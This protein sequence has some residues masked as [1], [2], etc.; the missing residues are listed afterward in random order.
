MSVI[1]FTDTS[2]PAE[3]SLTKK[4][5]EYT[6]GH[7]VTNSNFLKVLLE[8]YKVTIGTPSEVHLV[9]TGTPMEVST[10]TPSNH[11]EN[12]EMVT[13]DTLV[14]L[15]DERFK[16]ELEPINIGGE[17]MYK[18]IQNLQERVIELEKQISL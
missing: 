16:K 7:Q 12:K 18:M 4:Q 3:F 8:V 15:L 10:G 13:M 14:H 5:H 9:T 1:K 6:C 2:S 11:T 17:R